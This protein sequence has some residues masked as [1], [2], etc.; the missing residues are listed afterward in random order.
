[1]GAIDSVSYVVGVC[2]LVFFFFLLCVVVGR[3]RMQREEGGEEEREERARSTEEPPPLSHSPKR[4]ARATTPT[5]EPIPLTPPAHPKA[6]VLGAGRAHK[7]VPQPP[8]L[9][10]RPQHTRATTHQS[11]PP[12]ANVT[13]LPRA[14]SAT[15]PGP[16]AARGGACAR[17]RRKGRESAH[18]AVPTTAHSLSREQQQG[19]LATPRGRDAAARVRRAR[20]RQAAPVLRRAV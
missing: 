8:T 9:L 19:R 16:G 6:S 4:G 3:R 20:A 2:V 13:Q 14:L 11:N 5:P 18:L 10:L 1:M 7:V 15:P 12:T 17:A